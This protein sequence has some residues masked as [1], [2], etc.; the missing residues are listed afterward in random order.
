[1]LRE[2]GLEPKVFGDGGNLTLKVSHELEGGRVRA[3]HIGRQLQAEWET[4]SM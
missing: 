1:M 2:A 4:T 3:S